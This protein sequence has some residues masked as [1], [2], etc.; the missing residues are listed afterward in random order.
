MLSR[1]DLG[2]DP[3]DIV[4]PGCDS[5]LIEIVGA[6]APEDSEK[7]TKDATKRS[8]AGAGIGAL[9]GAALGPAGVALGS[10]S[11]AF[12]AGASTPDEYVRVRCQDCGDVH[13]IPAQK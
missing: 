8:L 2:F 12:L 13:D 9:F 3:T 10:G 1:A 4:C 6:I 5:S 7:A 11:G